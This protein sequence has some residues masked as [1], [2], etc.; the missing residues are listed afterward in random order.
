MPVCTITFAFLVLSKRSL[1][2]CACLGK[3]Y[4]VGQLTSCHYVTCCCVCYANS[5]VRLGQSLLTVTG[6]KRDRRKNMRDQGPAFSLIITFSDCISSH[7]G[8]GKLWAHDILMAVGGKKGFRVMQERHCLCQ[9]HGQ[10][11]RGFEALSF[12]RAE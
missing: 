8:P 7:L 5:A 9:Y 12:H 1:S 6:T 11:H 3:S 10:L 4:L 2:K